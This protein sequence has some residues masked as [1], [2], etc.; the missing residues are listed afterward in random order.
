MV[1]P[2]EMFSLL[3]LIVNFNPNMYLTRAFLALQN[4]GGGGGHW[5]P[6]RISLILHPKLTKLGTI[7]DCDKLYFILVVKVLNWL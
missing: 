1:I 7:V 2:L 6:L 5:A 4:L 3:F